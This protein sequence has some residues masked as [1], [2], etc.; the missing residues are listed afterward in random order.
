MDRA[1]QIARN[2][3]IAERF[4]DGYHGSVARGRLAGVFAPEDFADPWVF[5]SPYLGGESSN[6]RST[7]MQDGA[8]GNHASIWAKIPDYKMDDFRAWPT[9]RG[10]AWRWRV[11]GHGLDGRLY[12]FWEQLFIWTDDDGLITRFEFYDDWHGF[13]QTLVYAY[14]ATLDAFTKIEGYGGPPWRPGAAMALSPT[15]PPYQTPPA[16]D[17]VG[18]N[19]QIA[20]RAFDAHR[21]ALAQGRLEDAFAGAFADAWVLFSPWFGEVRQRGGAGYAER[22]AFERKAIWRRLPDYGMDQFQAWPTDDGCAWRWRVSGRSAEGVAYEYWEQM[23]ILTDEDGRI[24]RLEIFDDWQGFPQTLG[25][26][27]G[28]GLDELGDPDRYRAWIRQE[29]T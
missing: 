7:Y 15:P 24:I 23:F 10:C 26:V 3:D 16:N 21:G 29:P 5:C 19:L 13:A 1:R 12:Q 6:A 4:Y 25:F 11:N 28:L 14:G 17:R 18:R 8:V 9:E 20:Q 27:T 2:L 22:A